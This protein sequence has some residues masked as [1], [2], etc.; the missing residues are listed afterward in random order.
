MLSRLYEPFENCVE[1]VKYGFDQNG[2]KQRRNEEQ[3]DHSQ[4]QHLI[5]LLRDRR[6]DPASENEQD[7]RTENIPG[8]IAAQLCQEGKTGTN[9][10]QRQG[11]QFE[12]EFYQSEHRRCPPFTNIVGDHVDLRKDAAEK[13]TQCWQAA[14][15]FPLVLPI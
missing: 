4:Q 12:G 7:Q 14:C 2:A 8:E 3:F 1:P 5:P 11:Q 9:N 10:H 13:A 15:G 6:I